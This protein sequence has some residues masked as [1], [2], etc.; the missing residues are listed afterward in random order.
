MGV[1]EWGAH[2][3]WGRP[4]RSYWLMAQVK[5]SVADRP[6]SALVADESSWTEMT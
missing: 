4:T 1:G 6:W 2:I 5:G 3:I